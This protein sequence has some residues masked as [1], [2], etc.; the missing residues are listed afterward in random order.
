MDDVARVCGISKKTLYSQF[1]NK[2][3]LVETLIAALTSWFSSVYNELLNNSTNAINE[4]F[5]SLEIIESIYRKLHYRMF[6]DLEK[7]YYRIWRKVDSFKAESGLEL[8]SQ[9]IKRGI[10]EG[11]FIDRLDIDIIAVMRLN[12]LDMIHR[13]A[14]QARN[15][16]TTLFQTTAHYL[17]GLA[18]KKGDQEINKFLVTNTQ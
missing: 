18:T 17:R 11:L 14:Q 5:G 3:E 9:N 16:H 7:H 2:Y 8:I 6:D 1:A 10:K 12:Q 13:Q 15:L 4:V